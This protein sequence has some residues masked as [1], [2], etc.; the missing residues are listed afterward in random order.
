MFFFKDEKE[1]RNIPYRSENDDGESGQLD[2]MLTT[3]FCLNLYDLFIKWIKYYVQAV[4]VICISLNFS[5]SV[6]H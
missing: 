5:C 1:T 3:Y 6:E 4:L 2:I